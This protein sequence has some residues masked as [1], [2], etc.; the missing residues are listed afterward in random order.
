M[1]PLRRSSRVVWSLLGA[2]LVVC[3][4]AG[5]VWAQTSSEPERIA[6]PTPGAPD[7]PPAVMNVLMGLAIL[8]LVL[9]ATMLPAKRSHQD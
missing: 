8:A 5:S 2:G 6:P 9:F 7:E 1:K 4:H 3:A